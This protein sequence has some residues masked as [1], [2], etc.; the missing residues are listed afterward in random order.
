MKVLRVLKKAVKWYLN[1]CAETY[2][3]LP[4]CSFPC[5]RFD[6]KK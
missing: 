1:R 6:R 2:V 5:V 3:F 4:T